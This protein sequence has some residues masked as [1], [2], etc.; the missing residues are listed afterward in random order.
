MDAANRQAWAAGGRDGIHHEQGC[1][2]TWL[3]AS[4]HW[5]ALNFSEEPC[6]LFKQK[7]AP[8]YA[9]ISFCHFPQHITYSRN[10][11]HYKT[12]PNWNF[13]FKKILI[14]RQCSFVNQSP[15]L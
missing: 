1:Y 8:P 3:V 13:D 6:C 14:V 9:Y 12:K 11:L 4:S 7:L 5:F 10:Q 2:D 15:A